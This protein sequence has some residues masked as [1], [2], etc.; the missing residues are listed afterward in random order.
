MFWLR[1]RNIIAYPQGWQYPAITEQHAYERV[2]ESLPDAPNIVYIGFPWA[3]LIDFL[4]TQQLDKANP[5]LEQLK[6]IPKS[7]SVIKITVAQHIYAARYIELFESVGITDLFWS[8]ASI[9][10]Q[11]IH[12]IRIH[13][14]PLFPV[15]CLDALDCMTKPLQSRKYLYSFVGAY[16]PVHYLSEARVW[17]STLPQSDDAFV[18]VTQEWHFNNIVYDKQVLGN[19]VKPEKQAQLESDA[20]SYRNLL[21]DTV[22]SLCPSGSGPN[23]IRLWESLGFGCI[24]VIIADMLRLPG[25][26]LEWQEAAI[27]IREEEAA[28]SALPAILRKIAQD[29]SRLYNIVLAGR[30]LWKKYGYSNFIADILKLSET[31]M[32]KNIISKEN[33]KIA[34]TASTNVK[35]SA[36]KITVVTPS[37]NQ[38]DYLEECIDSILSQNYPNLE[39]IIM[40]GGSTDGSVEIIKKYKKYLAYWQSQPDG[41]Q[42][43]AI[44]EGVHRSSGEIMTWLNSDDKFHPRAFETVANI[45][46]ERASVEWIMGRPNGFSPNGVQSWVYDYL[47]LWS[48]E[49][50]LRKEYRNPYIQQEGTFWRRSLWE[51]AGAYLRSDLQLA[52]DLEL[53]TRFFR[54]AQLYT[55]DAMLAGY[56]QHPRQKSASFLEEYNREAENILDQE[57]ALFNR[58]PNGMLLPAPPPILLT[59]DTERANLQHYPVITAENFQEFT[60][61]RRSHFSRLYAHGVDPDTCD[62]KVI[63]DL[64]IIHFIFGNVRLGARLLEVGG[65]PYSRVIQLLKSHYE[66]WN[67]DENLDDNARDYRS[68]RGLLGDMNPKLPSDYFDCIFSISALEHVHNDLDTFKRVC[69]DADRVLKAGGFSIH[70][71]DVVAQNSSV[72]TNGL[73]PYIFLHIKTINPPIFFSDMLLD[74]DLYVLSEF[75]YNTGWQHTTRLS[76]Q[77]FGQ[78]LA[79]NVLWQKECAASQKRYGSMVSFAEWDNYLTR[80][81]QLWSARNMIPQVGHQQVSSSFKTL[82]SL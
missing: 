10:V 68:V 28:I 62:L 81:K 59:A 20:E 80:L 47:P 7:D 52:G 72:W 17:I 35:L 56:R 64:V 67:I 65:G 6:Q 23:S 3:T 26:L 77:K 30:R 79:Y 32:A 44:N 31:I 22:F 25:N 82:K 53:W 39:Y 11:M 76:Y 4:Q 36:P 15:R 78:P 37:F 45:F 12:A 19:P 63:Q 27:F 70:S 1:T 69:L 48:R 49:K 13:P 60:Y 46:M 74:Q 55:A 33:N 24:P 42:Y 8:H 40:D 34:N 51:K 41:G 66:I 16:D 43:A 57:R 38:A 18:R 50:Y 21:A 71:F 14:F 58:V 75:A 29:Y 73:L 9:D 2:C 61:S 54:Y 5:Y